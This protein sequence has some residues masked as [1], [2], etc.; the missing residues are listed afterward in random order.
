MN[1]VFTV[2]FHLGCSE[3][4]TGASQALVPDDCLSCFQGLVETP[5]PPK[6]IYSCIAQKDIN[7][8]LETA[9]GTIALTNPAGLCKVSDK[10]YLCLFNRLVFIF[11]LT[12]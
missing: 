5:Q 10:L 7:S 1:V 6:A 3:C 9:Y 4:Y 2:A 12:V 11:L 8:L